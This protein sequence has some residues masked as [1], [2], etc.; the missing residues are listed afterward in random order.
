[1]RCST[2]RPLRFPT[3]CSWTTK[4][5]PAT[6]VVC[7]IV[8]VVDPLTY[9]HSKVIPPIPIDKYLLH[10]CKYMK[11]SKAGL[12]ITMIYVD[13]LVSALEH[14]FQRQGG[15]FP[16]LLTSYN[17]HRYA[18][19]KLFSRRTVLSALLLAQKYV[20]ERFSGLKVVAQ[21]G[22]VSLAELLR[23]EREFL[24]ALQFNVFV[25]VRHFEIYYQNLVKVGMAHAEHTK[26]QT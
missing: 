26:V 3:E 20:E 21:I 15:K 9:F 22:G 4:N 8:T 6:K 2:E 24:Q 16:F 17:A 10:L 25:D 18:R 14:A 1:M 13:K 5:S 11:V 19:T 12:V 7:A 23:L